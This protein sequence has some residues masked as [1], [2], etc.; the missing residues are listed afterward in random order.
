MWIGQFLCASPDL[1]H[2][3]LVAIIAIRENHRGQSSLLVDLRAS[4]GDGRIHGTWYVC[5]CAS[6]AWM[7][8]AETGRGSRARSCVVEP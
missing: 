5:V 6:F 3:D 2:S 1:F 4:L 8:D 7:L